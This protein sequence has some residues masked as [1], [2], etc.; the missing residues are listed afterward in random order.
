MAASDRRSLA[1]V[2]DNVTLAGS[3][4]ESREEMAAAAG[5]GEALRDDDDE[6]SVLGGSGSG[7]GSPASIYHTLLS[8]YLTPPPPYNGTTPQLEPALD[9]LSRHGARLPASST[10]RLIPETLPVAQLEAY[11]RG[12][13]RAAHSAV[14]AS[15]IEKG[16]RQTGVLAAQASLLLGEDGDGRAGRSRHVVVGEERACGVCHKRL[17]GSVVA[18]LADNAVVHYGCLSRAGGRPS[19]PSWQG[20]RE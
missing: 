18:V 16:L 4:R 5:F 15:R 12:R 2:G 20:R 13:M 10:L 17:G 8:L 14:H 11:F 6:S 7:S 9:L 1:S 19:R 3:G